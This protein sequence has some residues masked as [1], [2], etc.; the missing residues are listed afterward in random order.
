MSLDVSRASRLSLLRA[1]LGLVLGGATLWLGLTDGAI[2]LWGF[3]VASLLQ[4]PGALSLWAR[5]RDGLGNS[6][7]ERER[8]T[9]KTVGLLLRFLALGMAMAAVSA[10]LGDRVPEVGPGTLAL[11]GLAA[12][13]QGALWLA[14]RGQAGIHPA[15]DLGTARARTL[16]ELAGLL[17]LGSL[18]D[19]WFPWADAGMALAMALRI[20]LEGR[21]LGRAS[22]LQAAACGGCGCGCG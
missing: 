11:A 10:F 2:A 6:G 12:G 17:L 16:V 14:K 9:L 20:Y 19:R 15:L 13:L 21:A 7:L 22:T 3:G 4:V 18:L 1:L 8:L 5:I